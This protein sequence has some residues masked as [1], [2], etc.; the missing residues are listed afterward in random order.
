MTENYAIFFYSPMT[1]ETRLGCLLKNRFHV[2]ECMVYLE[3]EP[4][5]V[6]IVN[7][8]SGEVKE[9]QVKSIQ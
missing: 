4:T 5:D 2:S 3:N 6:F 1:Y 7:L 9:M 8:K